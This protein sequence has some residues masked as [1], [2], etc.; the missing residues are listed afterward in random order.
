M[1]HKSVVIAIALWATPSY[2]DSAAENLLNGLLDLSRY[3]LLDGENIEQRIPDFIE[4]SDV[5]E[6]SGT[7]TWPVSID[8]PFGMTFAFQVEIQE[9]DE[10][11]IFGFRCSRLSE[12]THA[13]LAK[14]GFL[15]RDEFGLS[16]LPNDWLQV[17]GAYNLPETWPNDVQAEV[18]CAGSSFSEDGVPPLSTDGLQAFFEEF[19]NEE[20][21]SRRSW[22]TMMV[23]G[24]TYLFELRSDVEHPSHR[25]TK[26][27]VGFN[28]SFFT[29]IEVRGNLLT[30][31]S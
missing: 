6:V 14:A 16:R 3:A 20:D 23:T 26:L 31:S 7:E 1:P 13:Y 15:G 24:E 19:I 2:A 29:L 17:A 22:P 28:D 11:S 18:S 10:L 21:I 4:G 30:G 9:R 8:D 12:V 25:T 5:T 27:R